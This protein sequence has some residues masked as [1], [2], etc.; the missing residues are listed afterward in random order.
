MP[1]FVKDDA[2][3]ASAGTFTEQLATA[4]HI[5]SKRGLRMFAVQESLACSAAL[6]NNP[7]DF[8]LNSILVMA[9]LDEGQNPGALRQAHLLA[10]TYPGVAPA[11]KVLASALMRCQKPQAA[12]KVLEEAKQQ[13]PNKTDMD[14]RLCLSQAAVQA[15]Q[16]ELARAVLE[17]GIRLLDWPS[18]GRPVCFFNDASGPLKSALEKMAEPSPQTHE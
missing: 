5:G 14:M 3:Y 16:P 12:L 17:E 9:L 13:D 8:Y 7:S 10:D 15:G 11:E 1:A 6:R 4:H 2:V 18:T